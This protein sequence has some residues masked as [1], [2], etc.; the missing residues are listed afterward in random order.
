MIALVYIEAI[1][2]Q[3]LPSNTS[4]MDANFKN[5]RQSISIGLPIHAGDKWLLSIRLIV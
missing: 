1:K 2:A 3:N 4:N 5:V